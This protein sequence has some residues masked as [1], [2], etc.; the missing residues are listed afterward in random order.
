[1][2]GT[3][4]GASFKIT[5]VTDVA[6]LEGTIVLSNNRHGAGQHLVV[7]GWVRWVR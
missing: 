7:V 1:M 4:S 2:L 5:N 3:S 6:T